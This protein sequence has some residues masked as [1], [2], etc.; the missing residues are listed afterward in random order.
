M[1]PRASAVGAPSQYLQ[2]EWT[3]STTASV[4]LRMGKGGCKEIDGTGPTEVVTWG[5][6]PCS[7]PREASRSS[8]KETNETQRARTLGF[9]HQAALLAKESR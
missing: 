6:R 1:G 9:I 8:G 5:G 7:L 4:C 3:G 2:N